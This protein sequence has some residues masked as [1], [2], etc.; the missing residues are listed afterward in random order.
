MDPNFQNEEAKTQRVK[1]LAQ[2]HAG[3]G[4]EASEPSPLTIGSAA[5]QEDWV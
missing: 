4:N 2:D 3:S 1:C 5:S